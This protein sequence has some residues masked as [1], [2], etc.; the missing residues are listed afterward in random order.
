M[1]RHLLWLVAAALSATLTL[2]ARAADSGYN[3]VDLQ[4][5]IEIIL[6][7][8]PSDPAQ[9]AA[10]QA[11]TPA[12]QHSFYVKRKFLI[13]KLASG[14]TKPG[15]KSGIRW[16]K[17]KVMA[18]KNKITDGASVAGDLTGASPV[19]WRSEPQGLS[20]E[21][22]AFVEST[23][24]SLVDNFW[25][26]ST[27]IARA[28]GL[29]LTFVGGAIFNTTLGG[30]GTVLGRSLSIDLGVDF[31]KQEGYIRF[32]YDKQSKK[33]GGLSFDIGLMFDVLLHVTNPAV[34]NGDTIEATHVK[35]P[36]IGCFR[37][38][39]DY[40]AW[41]AQ[42]GVS[43]LEFAGA[44]LVAAGHPA[45]GAALVTGVRAVG[46]ATV[47]STNLERRVLSQRRL[48][49]RALRAL[50]LSGL[51]DLARSLKEPAAACEEDL[52]TSS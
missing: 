25:A 37:Y 42:V 52:L 1:K 15:L 32:V 31:K 6:P 43:V 41:G 4:S 2:S 26:N 36:L 22:I 3:V 5:G 17:N 7:G 10:F 44:W 34:D 18:L 48:S 33:R 21:S 13:T 46:M 47:Y 29:G 35:L 11:L 45:E 8:L 27:E 30:L 14:L 38:G 39:P 40:R 50:G 23:V 28:N 24:T 19:Q 49:E 20:P 12:E 9:L 51:L 16:V